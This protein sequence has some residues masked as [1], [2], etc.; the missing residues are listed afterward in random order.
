MFTYIRIMYYYAINGAR[1]LK[2]TLNID[3]KDINIDL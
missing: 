3:L 1:S 2:L